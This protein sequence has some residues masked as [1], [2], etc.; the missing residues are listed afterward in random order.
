MLQC[1]SKLIP[2]SH[3]L[4]II[5][6]IVL[7]GVGIAELWPQTLALAAYAAAVIAIA[8]RAFRKSL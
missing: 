4:V 3:Y 7:K 6:G 2:T 1:V 5:R 8:A